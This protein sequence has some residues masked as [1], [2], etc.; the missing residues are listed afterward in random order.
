MLLLNTGVD[1]NVNLERHSFP[2]QYFFTDTSMTF[3][4]IFW[5]FPDNCQNSSTFPDVPDMRSHCVM[6]P[7]NDNTWTWQQT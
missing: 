1:L 7:V 4:S 6:Q 2:W 3:C 5:H